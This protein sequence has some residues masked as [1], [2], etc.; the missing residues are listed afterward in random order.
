MHDRA[1]VEAWGWLVALST[2]TT[3]LTLIDASGAQGMAAA[4]GVLLLAGLKAR[5]ILARY[6]KLG[7]SRF[8]MSALG[9]AIGG[10]LALGFAIYLAGSGGA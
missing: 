2:A 5:I 6:L 8:W 4:A 10:F 7:P 1:L 3:G 9:G